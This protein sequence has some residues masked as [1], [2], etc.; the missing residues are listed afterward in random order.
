MLAMLI[1]L[2]LATAAR[3][4]F[5]AFGFFGAGAFFLGIGTISTMSA[6]TL[7]ALHVGDFINPKL[8]VIVAL[9]VM[10]GSLVAFIGALSVFRLSARYDAMIFK[11]KHFFEGKRERMW[12]G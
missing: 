8:F 4:R 11:S 5:M 7:A 12:L 1:Q 9:T 6:Q 2:A 3:L 10:V